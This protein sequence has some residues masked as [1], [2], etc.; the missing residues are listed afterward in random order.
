MHI[1]RYRSYSELAQHE[2]EGIDF[3]RAVFRRAFSAVAVIAPHG[4]KIESRTSEIARAIAGE[5]FNLYLFEGIKKRGNYAALHVTSRRFDEP[6]CLELLSTC[7]FVIAI[8]GCVG[9]D[10]RV[11]LGGLDHSLKDK[12]TAE[13]REIGIDVQN[14]GHHFLATDL[15]NICNRGQSCKGVQLELTKA[16]RRSA[17]AQRVAEAVRAALLPLQDTHKL[18]SVSNYFRNG[19]RM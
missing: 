6:S 11:L 15:S 2:V 7:S 19:G 5:D 3:R 9:R 8:H 10:E 16:L 13:I 18:S 14:D 17:N 4:G 1:D 12:V